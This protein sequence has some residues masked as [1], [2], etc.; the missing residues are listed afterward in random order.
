M[1][2]SELT[3]AQVMDLVPVRPMASDEDAIREM[4]Q[5]RIGA[6]HA[7]LHPWLQK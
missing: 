7:K 1:F 5:T 2:G 6:I 4:L 3:A